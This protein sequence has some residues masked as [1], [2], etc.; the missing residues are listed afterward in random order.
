MSQPVLQNPFFVY[1]VRLDARRQSRGVSRCGQCEKVN[2]LSNI[3]VVASGVGWIQVGL[4]GA[5]FSGVGK[6]GG[7]KKL[8]LIKSI[9]L[10]CVA[11][12]V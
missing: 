5:G 10:R 11:G 12:S 2:W 8:K 7:R 1:L 6:K 4:V 3:R 9:E